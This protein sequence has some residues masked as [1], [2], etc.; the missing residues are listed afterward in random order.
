MSHLTIEA[1]A[2]CAAL[3]K[4]LKTV[5]LF[6]GVMGLI[7]F[8]TTCTWAVQKAAFVLLA[9]T[10]ML[11]L[12]EW[13][14]LFRIVFDAKLFQQLNEGTIES[15]E[16]LDAMLVRLGLIKQPVITR[17]LNDRIAGTRRLILHFYITIALQ[18]ALLLVA[19]GW[20]NV[21]VPASF[22]Y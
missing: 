20:H 3:S 22:F 11:A 14:Y 8:V 17:H 15:L 16:A 2:S 12:I 21:S 4:R 10:I 13:F 19:L 18:L 7:L 9:V 5:A 6:G 1:R